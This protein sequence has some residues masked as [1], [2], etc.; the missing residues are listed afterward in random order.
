MIKK[1]DL[2]AEDKKVW[3]EYTKNPS[4]IYDKDKLN[5]TG[6]TRKERFKFDLHG[7]TLDE[8]NLKVRE[9]ILSCIKKNYKEIL[10]I[11]G[12]GLH[13]NTDKDIYVSKD[14]SK[15]KFSVP[16]FINNNI[17]L[18]DCVF[19]ISEANIKD[20]GSGAILIKLKNL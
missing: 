20:G 18:K 6:N 14:L 9:I 13:S 5:T 19:S 17:E 4:N 1:K 16:E 7:F 12:K 3:E 11:T 10:L 8:A 15:L 2:P